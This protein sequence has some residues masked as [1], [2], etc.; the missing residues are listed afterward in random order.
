MKTVEYQHESRHPGQR[1]RIEPRKGFKHV[2][3]TDFRQ[4]LREQGLR[5][6]MVSSMS[7]TGKSAYALQKND[8][9][10][11]SHTGQNQLEVD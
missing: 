5:E 10:S 4:G 1:T 9:R 8:I 3:S 11:L 6:R 2:K 7:G